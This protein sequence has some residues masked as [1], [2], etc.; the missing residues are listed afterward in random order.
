MALTQHQANTQGQ[1]P[2]SASPSLLMETQGTSWEE[3]EVFQ[4]PPPARTVPDLREP[5]AE[6]L[7]FVNRGK[8]S[9]ER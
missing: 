8:N 6:L 7:V 2:R 5:A 1:P 3:T 9:P 4:Q